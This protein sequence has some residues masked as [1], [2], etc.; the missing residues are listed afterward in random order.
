M[1]NIL[2]VLVLAVFSSSPAAAHHG[3]A[4]FDRTTE[5]TL[6]G[7]VTDFYFV[8]PHCVVEFEVRDANGKIHEWKGELTN[9]GHLAPHGWTPATLKSGDQI[10]ISGWAAKNGVTSIWVTKISVNGR[11]LKL[12]GGN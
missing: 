10:V 1:K 7:E 8:N 9:P 12:G 2:P 5:V 3:F 11:D 4:N 6:K